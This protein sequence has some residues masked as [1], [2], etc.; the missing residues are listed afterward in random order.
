MNAPPGAPESN[1]PNSETQA[2]SPFV[3]GRPVDAVTIA[4][5]RVYWIEG[6][7]EGDVLLVCSAGTVAEALPAGTHVASKVHEYGGGAYQI[8]D[9]EIWFV[10]AEDQRI[11][12]TDHGSLRPVTPKPS[13]GQHRHADLHIGPQGQLVCVRE[14]HQDG[15]VLNE[16]V[17][18]PADGT[19]IPQVIGQGWD[20]YSSPRISPDGTQLAW[21]TWKPPLMPWDGSWLWTATISPDGQL[22]PQSLIAGGV[23][24]SVTQPSWSPDGILHFLSDRDGWWNLYRHNDGAAEQ[25]V[26][27]EAEMGPAPW[28]FGYTTYQLLSDD[29]VAAIVQQG[30]R[31]W[32]GLSSCDRGS[33][34]RIDLPYTSI[35]PY[36]AAEGGQ[37]AIIGSTLTQTSAVILVEPDRA[38]VQ[39]L[40]QP[41]R[42]HGTSHNAT[43]EQLRFPTRD[44]SHAHAVLY[45]AGPSSPAVSAIAPLLVRAHPGPTSNTNLRL[46]PW[47]SFFTGHGFAVLDVDYRGSTGYGR[48]YRNALRGNWGDLDVTDCV[49]AVGYLTANRRTDP[50]RV[51]ICG[52]SAG[53]YTALRAVTTTNTF[54]AAAVR[55]ALIDPA[56]WTDSAPKFQAHHAELLIGPP[57]DQ[58]T[59]DERSVLSSTDAVT[60]PVLIIHGDADTVTPVSQARKL[61]DVLGE[62]ATLITFA[63]EGHGLRHP[64]HSSQALSAELDHLR[65]NLPR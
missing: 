42:A 62:R 56:T 43:P 25:V 13:Q 7:A 41:G 27:V 24:E 14:R 61:A 51:A 11:W 52:S 53:G 4:D 5:R 44:N 26:T 3:E 29:L 22:G 46:D 40:T 55:H 28:E 47:I 2:A 64:D 30:P 38:Q 31:T 21:I 60:A 16:L 18:M 48:A 57:S 6:R 34:A 36:L 45:P 1:E 59:Y 19:A 35:K 39:E 49:D 10:R 20:F 15:E 23:E 63:N 12:R 33:P 17:T 32:L 8:H 9:G 50:A 58:T 65:R 54:A 37:L